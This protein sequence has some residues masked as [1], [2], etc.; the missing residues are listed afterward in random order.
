MWMYVLIGVFFGAGYAL[1]RFQHEQEG[2]NG[3]TAR[4][5]T[6]SS[7]NAGGEEGQGATR[8]DQFGHLKPILVA[9]HQWRG[10]SLDTAHMD[11]LLELDDVASEETKRSRRARMVSDLNA[12]AW[13][14]MDKPVLTRI[15]DE[16]DRRRTLYVIDHFDLPSW[17]SPRSA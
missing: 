15:R 8:E 4:T 5:R 11:A 7:T 6:I 13:T 3:K 10:R 9:L 17:A 12:W 1:G 14:A 16:E 2:A